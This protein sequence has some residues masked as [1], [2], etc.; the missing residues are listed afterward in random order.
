MMSKEKELKRWRLAFCLLLI[1]FLAWAGYYSMWARSQRCRRKLEDD[2]A[3]LCGD[4]TL[5]APTSKA[6]ASVDAT[7]GLLDGS[8]SGGDVEMKQVSSPLTLADVLMDLDD[9]VKSTMN[10][11]REY[12]MLSRQFEGSAHILPHVEHALEWMGVANEV[13]GATLKEAKERA[14]RMGK[15]KFQS[16]EAE[17]RRNAVLETM[18]MDPLDHR[19]AVVVPIRD[20]DMHVRI[21]RAVVSEFL[22]KQGIRYHLFFIEQADEQKFNR[23]K[24]L[25]IG[26]ALAKQDYDYFALHD[27]D[28]IPLYDSVDY[29]YP[30]MPTHLASCVE[31][32]DWKIPYPQFFGGVV[33]INREHMQLI[34]GLSN[35]YWGWGAEDDDMRQ[36]I[37]AVGLDYKRDEPFCERGIFKSLSEDHTERDPDVEREKKLSY[38]NS[39]MYIDGLNTLRYRVLSRQDHDDAKWSRIKVIL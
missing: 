34:N 12:F 6:L 9:Q 8:G 27:V 23:A 10:Q 33:L 35:R 28:M 39:V 17:K 37:T 19:L 14:K 32:F 26:F 22:Q 36:R 18:S 16:V 4:K 21:F 11:L 31:Q 3:R 1:V 24:L 15:S 7:L 30:L 2:D 29:S 13:L 25:N 38:A 20:R 5:V